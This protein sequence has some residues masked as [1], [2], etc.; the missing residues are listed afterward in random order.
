LMLWLQQV[1]GEPW[2]WCIRPEEIDLFLKG[3]G[4]TNALALAG[5]TRKY[6]VE[7]Y[8]VATK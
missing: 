4:W 3:S 6:G 7:F 5:T 2:T 1:V 8:A